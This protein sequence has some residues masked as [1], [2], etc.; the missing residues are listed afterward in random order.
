MLSKPELT[1]SDGSS[2]AT[3]TSRCEQVADHVLV[4]GAVEAV[5]GLR[6]ARIGARGGRA[7]ELALEP[8]GEAVLGGAVRARHA[9][10]RHQSRTQLQHHLLPALRR[11]RDV[12]HIHRG[13]EGDGRGA[14]SLLAL[15]VAA[16]AVLIEQRALRRDG[17]G[18]GVGGLLRACGLD[19]PRGGR[20]EHQPD[21]SGGRDHQPQRC[22]HVL[23]L[24]SLI[25][26]PSNAHTTRVRAN[27]PFV[28]LQLSTVWAF[29]ATAFRR[30]PGARYPTARAHI[31]P[32]NLEVTE[33]TAESAGA[34]G[35]A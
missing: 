22:T 28:E 4:F 31:G 24:H 10:G 19:V 25:L 30:K 29:R 18:S 8:G 12:R 2:D 11:G 32:P 26:R 34:A 16:D 5:E 13:V 21:E 6:A 1:S 20:H 33:A 3:S 27:R 35:T 14:S 7:I 17:S 15:V 9:G 23:R